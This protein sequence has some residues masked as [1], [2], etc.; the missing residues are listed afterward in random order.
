MAASAATATAGALGEFRPPNHALAVIGL[1]LATFM[2]VLDLTI[3]N[4]SLPTIAGNLGA[5]QDQS[6]WVITSFTVCN[7][8]ALPL[9]GFITRRFGEVKPFIAATLLFSLFSMMCGFSTS[10]GMLV[11]FRALQGAMA[12]PMYPITQSLMVSLYPGHKRGTALAMLAMIAICGPIVGPVLGGWITETYAW[13]W[14]FFINVPVGLFAA[15]VVAAQMRGRPEQIDKPRVDKVGLVTLILGVG[16]LQILLDKGNELDWFHSTTIV[17]LAIVAAISLS[18]FLIWEFTDRE[19]IVNFRLFKHRNFAAGTLAMV[20]AYAMFFSTSLLIQLWMQSTL[21]YTSIWAG[22]VSAPIG[23]FPLLL[24][25]IIG[26]Y[27]TRFDLRWF[28]S[29]S[30]LV[31]GITCFMRGGFNT[32]VDI[33]HVAMV[34]LIQ[35]LGVAFFFLPILTILLSDLNG[36]EVSDGSGL[37]TFLRSLGGS[38]AVSIVT[39][40][41]ERGSAIN[42]ANLTEHINDYS[43]QVR[44]SIALT[45]GYVQRYAAVINREIT[46]QATQISFNHLFVMLGFMF[47]A[48]IVVVWFARPPFIKQG[49]PAASGG[50]H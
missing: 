35:G 13:H 47:L 5:S 49:K 29:F 15:S 14:I 40:L 2:Q 36:R 12:G 24:S 50:G 30:F 39:Y 3:A 48:L 41:W 6:T 16:S 17:V 11:V 18:V 33:Y 4:V 10:L 22:I 32:Q 25:F 46:R 34:Q 44:Q 7:A 8:I 28:A 31:I 9:T 26:K 42:H 21:G 19:P 45:G 23:V 38:F 1:S 37:A 43:A 27:A 20:L